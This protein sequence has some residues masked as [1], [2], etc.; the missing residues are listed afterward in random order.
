[1]EYLSKLFGSPARVKLLRLFVFNPEEVYGRDDVVAAVRVTPNTASKELTA[2]ARAGLIKRK[3]FFKEVLPVGA[4]TPK[5]RKTLGWML[6]PKYP[7]QDALRIFLQQT[8]TISHAELRKRFR[9]AGRVQ[10]LIVAG[11]FVDAESV[12]DLLLVG[13][14]LDD[15]LVQRVVQGFEAECGREIRYTILTTEDFAYRK[16]VRDK[17]LRDVLDHP[18]EVL[19]DNVAI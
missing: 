17:L 12:L 19:V 4:K 18:H 15:A 10:A 16:R 7:H 13:D 1:M 2:L 8:L 9:G 11:F 14:R 6:D 3:T 5:R